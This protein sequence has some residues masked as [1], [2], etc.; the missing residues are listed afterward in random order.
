MDTKLEKGRAITHTVTAITSKSYVHRLLL[1]A[2]LYEKNVSIRS[3]ICSKDMEATVRV[4]NAL[5]GLVSVRKIEPEDDESGGYLFTI[6]RTLPEGVSLARNHGSTE[7]VV[8]DCGES[9]S[10]ARFILP[11]AALFADTVTVTGS[12]KLPARPMGP[13]CDVLRAAGVAVS[14]DYLPIT[15]SGKPC[16]GNYRIAGNV[17]SQFITGLL[18]MMP[19]IDGASSLEIEGALESAPYVDMTVE[20]LEKFGVDFKTENPEISEDLKSGTMIYYVNRTAATKNQAGNSN[21]SDGDGAEAAEDATVITA[22][23]DW[24]NAAYIMAIASL[25]CGSA[26]SEVTIEGLNSESIQ[27]DR[28][29]IRLLEKF[30]VSIRRVGEEGKSGDGKRNGYKVC[31]NPY[32][33]IDAD[34][35]QIPDLVPALAVIAAYNDGDSIFRNVERLRIKECDRIDA[36][37]D[38]LKQVNVLVDIT[39]DNGHENIIVHGKGMSRPSSETITIDSRNDHRIAMAAA[40]IAFAENVPVVIRD[41]MAVNKSYPGF[42]DVIEQLGMHHVIL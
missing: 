30:G 15:L 42:Y 9:G 17:S 35:S 22:E 12:G 1:A 16:A 31:G 39:Q 41:A 20:V 29:I 33:S 26:F 19:L 5:G 7:P 3:N 25:G 34:C 24:S 37:T 23:G 40:A 13:L 2:A 4:I 18:F 38:M 14:S 32:R 21:N 27:G 11:I 36:V 10:T 6:E 8:L 28:E